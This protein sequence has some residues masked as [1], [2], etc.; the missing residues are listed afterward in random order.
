M[1]KIT[2]NNG[3]QALPEAYRLPSPGPDIEF[4]AA[5]YALQILPRHDKWRYWDDAAREII[6]GLAVW[7]SYAS[8]ANITV[9]RSLIGLRDMLADD[10]LDRIV[11][12]I[13]TPAHHHLDPASAASIRKL[14]DRFSYDDSS[15]AEMIR[16]AVNAVIAAIDAANP[17]NPQHLASASASTTAAD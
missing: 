9:Q 7:L 2:T 5:R 16:H 6:A 3:I 10:Q 15:I 1:S 4:R 13:I 12:S 17:A 8:D 11:S 14:L